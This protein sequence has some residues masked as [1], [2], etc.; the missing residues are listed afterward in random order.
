MAQVASIQIGKPKT[1]EGE[2]GVAGADKPWTTAIYKEPIKGIVAINELG[3]EGDGQA[4]L[5]HHGGH[6]KAICVYTAEHYSYWQNQIGL[7]TNFSAGAF[8][9]SSVSRIA[10][11]WCCMAFE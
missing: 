6:D 11:C 10:C 2:P 4:D 9:A 3:V 8:S 7:P 5:K 1:Y